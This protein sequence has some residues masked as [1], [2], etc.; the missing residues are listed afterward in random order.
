MHISAKVTLC[1]VLL[2]AGTPTYAACK[3]PTIFTLTQANG[4]VVTLNGLRHDGSSFDGRARTQG[5]WGNVAGILS[6]T[7]QLKFTIDWGNSV[8]VYTGVVED[9]NVENGRSYDATHPEIRSSWTSN[10][11]INCANE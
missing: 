1:L 11:T 10:S 3:M 8:G 9:G 4:P 2:A 7:G 5:G 6:S